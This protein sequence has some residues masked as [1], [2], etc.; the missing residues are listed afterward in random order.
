MSDAAE[1][2]LPVW[3]PATTEAFASYGVIDDGATRQPVALPTKVIPQFGGL[4]ITT[5]STELQA[6]TD[7]LVYVVT[8]P[9]ECTEQVSSR[10]LSVVARTLDRD[11]APVPAG[12]RLA[13]EEGQQRP[14]VV[15][16]QVRHRSAG[17]PLQRVK[18]HGHTDTEYNS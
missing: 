10:L 15:H 3:T 5:S 1:L 11:V 13:Q 7:A 17:V 2:A 18:Q 9:F 6:L 4:E 14:A 8:Y 16:H 12:V